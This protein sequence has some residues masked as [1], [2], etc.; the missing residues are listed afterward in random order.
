M[1]NQSILSYFILMF[2]YIIIYFMFKVQIH[3]L[4]FEIYM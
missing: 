4:Q 1:F 2:I 3:V